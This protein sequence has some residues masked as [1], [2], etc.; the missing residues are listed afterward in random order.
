MKI[1]MLKT[2]LGADNGIQI[3]EY[4]ENEIYDLSES[5]CACF[6]NANLCELVIEKEE[7]PPFETKEEK[8]KIKTK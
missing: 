2:S 6:L 7:K 1:K 4:V 8:Q 3:K 5:L